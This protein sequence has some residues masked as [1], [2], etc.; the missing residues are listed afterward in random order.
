MDLKYNVMYFTQVLIHYVYIF[1]LY[2]CFFIKNKYRLICPQ[3]RDLKNY[4]NYSI[5]HID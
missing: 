4:I 3:S 5:I 1:F 2:K